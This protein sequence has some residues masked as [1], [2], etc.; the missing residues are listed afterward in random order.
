[1]GFPVARFEIT[2]VDTQGARAFYSRLFGW[3]PV[4]RTNTGVT[5]LHTGDGIDGTL[6]AAEDGMP[7]F[8]AVYVEVDDVER[9]MAEAES[10]GGTIYVPA[11]PSVLE[12]ERCFGLIGDPEGNLI[13]LVQR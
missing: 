2:A 4:A 8:V 9:V 13:G 11:G 3:K 7:T 10:L 1:M 6:I 5:E 12:G